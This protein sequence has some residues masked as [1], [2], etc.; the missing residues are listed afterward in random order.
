MG[1]KNMSIFTGTIYSKVMCMDTSLCVILPHDT[2]AHRGLEELRE[3]I[4]PR[5]VSK[6]LF[7]LHGL[8]DNSAAWPYRSNILRYAEAFDIAV[9]MPEVQRSFYQNMIN[10]PAYFTYITEELPA[11]AESMFHISL[12]PEDTIIAGESMGG[13]GAMYCGFTHPEYYY[14]IGC[15]SAAYDLESLVKSD[16]LSSR[17]D[18]AVWLKDRRGIFGEEPELQ[19]SSN[20][21]HLA[22]LACGAAKKPRIFMTCGTEDFLYQTNIRMRD[23]LAGLSFDY[24]YVEWQGSHE[25]GFF[26]KSALMMLEHFF[27]PS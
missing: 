2:R 11:L 15:F 8:S 27:K 24:R 14:G 4:K 13:Y 18:Q 1:D 12:V 20:L 7:L 6:T 19:E 23:Y 16:Y 3:A 5:D 22:E 26:D 21:Y 17:P 25:W 10:G 9:I